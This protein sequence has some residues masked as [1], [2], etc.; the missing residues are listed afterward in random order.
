VHATLQCEC[1][2]SK[3]QGQWGGVEDPINL[4]RVLLHCT[5][6]IE[7]FLNW[8][9][10]HLTYFMRLINDFSINYIWCPIAAEISEWSLHPNGKAQAVR[11]AG[12]RKTD[13]EAKHVKC[14]WMGTGH[15]ASSAKWIAEGE[16]VFITEVPANENGRQVMRAT[17]QSE[18]WKQNVCS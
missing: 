5:Y 13:V 18:L 3:S 11:W 8:W 1:V 14:W 6:C 2:V 9:I 4:S 15:A 16:C 7:L 12:P 17:L 10:I